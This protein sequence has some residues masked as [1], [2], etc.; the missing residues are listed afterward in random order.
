MWRKKCDMDWRIIERSELLAAGRV[1]PRS[2][3]CAW[4]ADWNLRI[5]FHSAEVIFKV[6]SINM[7]FKPWTWYSQT[8][9]FLKYFNLMHGFGL[10]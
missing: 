2:P 3:L 1:S 8:F 4:L 10:K 6:D 7:T 5:M 9:T